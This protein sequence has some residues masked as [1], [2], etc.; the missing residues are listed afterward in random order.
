MPER[1]TY[2]KPLLY[3][4]I[5]AFVIF[6]LCNINLK[7]SGEAPWY[8]FEGIDKVVHAC[9]FFVLAVLSYWGFYEQSRWKQLS[10]NAAVYAL[11][12]CMFYG[13]LIEVLQGTIFTYRSADWVDWIFDTAGALLGLWVF[14]LL[15][16]QYLK[17]NKSRGINESKV[18]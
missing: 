2:L 17:R 18:S 13:G 11:L 3:A 10:R 6:V 9:M 8:Y 16:K 4:L 12:L 5:W 7:T 1:N 14:S 15:K